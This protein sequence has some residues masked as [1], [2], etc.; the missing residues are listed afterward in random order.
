[1]RLQFNVPIDMNVQ[2]DRIGEECTE[3]MVDVEPAILIEFAKIS[4]RWCFKEI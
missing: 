1:M 3:C 4:V 2:I